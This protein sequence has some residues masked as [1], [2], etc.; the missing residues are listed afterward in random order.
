V[1]NLH[2]EINKAAQAVR[3]KRGDEANIATTVGV[4]GFPGVGMT[5]VIR[6]LCDKSSEQLEQ[7][8]EMLI[9]NGHRLLLGHGSIKL[10]ND[11][12]VLL[13][14]FRDVLQTKGTGAISIILRQSS[15]QSLLSFYKIADYSSVKDLLRQ[16]ALKKQHILKGGVPD[17]SGGAKVLIDDWYEGKI[18]YSVQ[19]FSLPE[20]LINGDEKSTSLSE[21]L[22]L[23]KLLP[24]QAE[25]VPEKV[26]GDEDMESEEDE[27][28]SEEV[29]E[30]D[31]G[32]EDGADSDMGDAG[33]EDNNYDITKY[34]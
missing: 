23:L 6:T 1:Q 3:V 12:G 13:R 26:Q 18:P 10:T 8:K 30:K 11:T 7:Q 17:V 14:N 20:E 29:E 28:I 21:N 9:E 4:V 2:N 31:V 19:N 25:I 5:S 27:E 32:E 33:E 16:I 15:K 24:S 34:F 22:V